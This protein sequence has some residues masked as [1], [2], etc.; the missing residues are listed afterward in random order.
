MREFRERLAGLSKPAKVILT[1]VARKLL[2]IANAII[3]S[4]RQ[5]QP[6]LAMAK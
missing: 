1:A 5:W 4:R 6:E 2:L 3:R